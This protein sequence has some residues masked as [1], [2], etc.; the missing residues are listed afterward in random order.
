MRFGRY[1]ALLTLGLTAVGCHRRQVAR[2]VGEHR[3]RS[4]WIDPEPGCTDSSPR[5]L[6]LTRASDTLMLVLPRPGPVTSGFLGG[7]PRPLAREA[8]I[9]RQVAGG[10]GGGPFATSGRGFQLLLRDTTQKLAALAALDTLRTADAWHVPPDSVRVRQARWDLAELYDWRVALEEYVALAG[11]ARINGWGIDPE[12]N[13]VFLFV[14][15]S[16]SLAA[17][18]RWLQRVNAPCRLVAAEVVGEIHIG[19]VVK[20]R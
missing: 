10:W 5:W 15:D 8:W 2:D 3:D 18:P 11:T 19:S 16:T 17:L 4:V 13:R 12:N 7:G 6:P 1:L 20:P 14:V 9:A